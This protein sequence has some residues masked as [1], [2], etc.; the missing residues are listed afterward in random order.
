MAL[1]WILAWIFV[2]APPSLWGNEE[3]AAREKSYT[4]REMIRTGNFYLLFGAMGF[5]LMSYFLI[6]PISQDVL[7]EKGIAPGLAAGAVTLGSAA[8][9]G[10][11]LLLPAWSDRVGRSVC[12]RWVMILSGVI[13]AVLW[14]FSSYAA[15]VAVVFL[16]GYYGGIMGLFPS[17]TSSIFGLR[18]AGENYAYVLLGMVAASLAA[19]LAAQR[20]AAAG[21]G[22]WPL[23]ALGITFTVLAYICM[24]QLERRTQ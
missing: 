3:T 6:S 2:A 7:A 5:G 9:A 18:H 11:R 1:A 8:N 24:I 16:Y 12:I 21:A 17:Y 10:L 23:F 13:M 4:T 15:V 20:A 22:R 19:P 14:L